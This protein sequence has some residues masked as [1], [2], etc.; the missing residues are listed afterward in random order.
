LEQ[1]KRG[2]PVTVTD[3]RMTRFFMSIPEAVQ[4]VLQAAALSRGGE[5]FMLEMGDSVSISHL[6]E[7]LI[8]LSGLRP[9]A[10]LEIRVTG[11]RPG[12]KLHE[13]LHEESERPVPTAHPSVL[14][15]SPA[16][17][18]PGLLRRAVAAL[19]L[20]TDHG[21]TAEARQ[22]LVDLAH[23]RTT[24]H[25]LGLLRLA[26]RRRSEDRG[27]AA[28]PTRIGQPRRRIGDVAVVPQARRDGDYAID[29]PAIASEP[30]AAWTSS[31]I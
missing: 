16:C 12:E 2:G 26:H 9:G 25:E 8:R 1:S 21:R 4:L 10:D 19:M 31:T 29:Q 23:D 13:V 6:A 14:R 30:S 27:I 24:E 28:K 15:L 5:V 18:S 17:P 11:I 22:L 7:R 20:L 3:G